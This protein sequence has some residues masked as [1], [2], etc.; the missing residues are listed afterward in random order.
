MKPK[1]H[2]EI[3]WPLSNMIKLFIKEHSQFQRTVEPRNMSNLEPIWKKWRCFESHQT[4]SCNSTNENLVDDFET[5]N[6][7]Y[8]MPSLKFKYSEKAPQ[9][10]PLRPRIC[11]KCFL[12]FPQ[13]NLSLEKTGTI[14]SCATQLFI[15]V[16]IVWEGHKIWKNLPPKNLTL[17][18]SV[19]F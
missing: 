4:I 6:I 14:K 2:F 8:S 12:W 7:S 5:K 17:L 16:R 11:V 3:N 19:K 18:S 10:I 15:K 1:G 13:K 9:K